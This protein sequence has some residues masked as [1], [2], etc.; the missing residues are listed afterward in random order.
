MKNQRGHEKIGLHRRSARVVADM[1]HSVPC[2]GLCSRTKSRN[3]LPT[4]TS[5]L[6]STIRSGKDTEGSGM[7]IYHCITSGNSL[8][9]SAQFPSTCARSQHTDD[10]ETTNTGNG[11][12]EMEQSRAT[13]SQQ[14]SHQAI[15]SLS[16][17]RLGSTCGTSQPQK[18]ST[19][20][21]TEHTRTS[22]QT[23]QEECDKERVQT[24]GIDKA[25]DKL[26]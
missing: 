21:M 12:I 18:S 17:K 1:S 2:I 24:H 9:M 22:T 13:S 4:K 3:V 23:R 25:N 6:R 26:S 7:S 15:R 14:K 8:R 20:I 11:F 10:T 16:T 5:A 19:S